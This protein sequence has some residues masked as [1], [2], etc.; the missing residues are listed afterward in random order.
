M[1]L[2]GALP[3]L[4]FSFEQLV[5]DAIR[6]GL[7]TKGGIGMADL[8]EMAWDDYEIVMAECRKTF[9]ELYPK[10]R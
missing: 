8:S 10:E 2:T 1:W 6:A 4:D 9:D 7:A 3:T 5:A